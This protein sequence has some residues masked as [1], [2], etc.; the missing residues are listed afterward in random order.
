MYPRVRPVVGQLPL[1]STGSAARTRELE[2]ATCKV[3]YLSCRR[4]R[5]C[6]TASPRENS[7]GARLAAVLGMPTSRDSLLRLVRVLPDSP[8]G[9]VEVLGV[10]DFAIRRCHTYG[11][12]L[13][14]I[15]ARRSVD[16]VEERWPRCG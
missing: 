9:D 16:L 15:L 5:V 7:S 6:C 4:L 14:D 10:D 11:T 13:V 8:I 1:T 12:V 3:R 2:T